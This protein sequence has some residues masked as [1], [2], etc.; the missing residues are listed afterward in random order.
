M[1]PNQVNLDDKAMMED[2]LSA[3]KHIT[4]EYNAFANECASAAVK[5]EL[6]NILN[7]EHQIQHEVFAEMQK[8]GWYQVEQADQSKVNQTKQKYQ[9]QCC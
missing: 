1:E 9:G 3:Q 5:T 2:V 8:R 4:G 7:E 6:I